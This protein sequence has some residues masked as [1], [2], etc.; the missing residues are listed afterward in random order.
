VAT[1]T[2][3]GESILAAMKTAIDTGKPSE[4]TLVDRSATR[5]LQP[6]EA[7]LYPIT[8]AARVV[9]GLVARELTVRVE[10]RAAGAIPD[11]ALDPALVWVT[12]ALMADPR[13]GG[14]CNDILEQSTAWDAAGA[15]QRYG[16][17]ARDF[18]V[19]YQ[20]LRTNPEAQYD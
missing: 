2:S 9:G 14:L 11:Q 6:G 13:L 16:A 3:V 1:Y 8:E 5:P 19:R 7:T 4:L 12:R 17:A 20:T 10:V 15:E 18:L